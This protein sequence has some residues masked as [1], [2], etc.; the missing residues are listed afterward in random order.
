L[1]DRDAVIYVLYRLIPERLGKYCWIHVCRAGGGNG[2][3]VWV[4][5]EQDISLKRLGVETLE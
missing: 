4:L 5:I 2:R 1:H 3:F